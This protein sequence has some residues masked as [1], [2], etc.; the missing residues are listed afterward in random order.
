MGE[1]D[2]QGGPAGAKAHSLGPLD[3]DDGGMI[4]EI[5][6]AESFEVMKIGDA[7]EIDV[8][9]ANMIFESVDESESGTGDFVFASGT[10]A[11]DE[12]FG[13]SCFARAEFAGEKDKGGRF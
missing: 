8:K 1:V 9:N 11:G 2:A 6:D 13:E 4:E 7:V 5:F 12:A 3:D 10:E